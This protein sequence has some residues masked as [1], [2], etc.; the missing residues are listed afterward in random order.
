M[1]FQMA[2]SKKM[3]AQQ[4]TSETVRTERTVRKANLDG[5]EQ[6]DRL[7]AEPFYLQ[8]SRMVERAIDTGELVAGDR[9]PNESELCRRYDLAR[10]TVREMLR[11]LQER[12]R[13]KLI[14]RRGAFVANS[15]Q[16]GW[17]LQVTAGF[18]EGEVDHNK[19]RVETEVLEASSFAL[20]ELAAASLGLDP[21]TIGFRLRRLR[22]LDG[23]LALYSENYMPA[24]FERLVLN[25]EVME[26][27]GSLNRVLRAAGYTIFGARRSVEA[28]PAPAP[29]AKLLEIPARSPLLLITSVSWGKDRRPFDF[30]RSFVRTDV[31]K[32]TVEAHAAGEDT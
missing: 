5:R 22:K 9:L 4:P 21:G 3:L 15:N 27:R 29:V 16:M 13:I 7:S 32:I 8:L 24:E 23:V 30:Y 14:P 19:R 17:G 6:I 11:N 31:V 10:S 18:F 25:S 12:G 26:T 20:P 2:K 28:V 1:G